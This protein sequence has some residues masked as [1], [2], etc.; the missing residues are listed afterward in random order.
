M[1]VMVNEGEV[2]A[3]VAER[4]W[5]EFSRGLLENTP[6]RMLL[7]LNACGALPKLFI[8]FDAETLQ[9]IC[10]QIDLAARQRF[11]L[12]QRFALFAQ[13]I[14]Q[15]RLNTLRLPIEVAEL[16]NLLRNMIEPM[17]AGSLKNATEYAHLLQRSDVIR[18]PERFTELLEVLCVAR[19]TFAHEQKQWAR[20]A[21][22]Y[23]S[24]NAGEIALQIA[25]KSGLIIQESVTKARLKAVEFALEKPSNSPGDK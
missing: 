24:V 19:P 13:Y 7:L 6:S 1:K 21:K 20:L 15:P 8:D 10:I 11:S 14:D 23:R 12:A 4:V 18:R 22:A 5:Q 2:D 9:A 16:A 17:T 3:L 25:S